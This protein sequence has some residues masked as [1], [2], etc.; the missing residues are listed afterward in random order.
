MQQEKSGNPGF[1]GEKI[2]P[3]LK[4]VNSLSQILLVG[5]LKILLLDMHG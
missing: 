1:E 4:E 2:F 3:R 5:Y